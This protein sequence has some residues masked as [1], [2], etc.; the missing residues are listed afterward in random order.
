MNDLIGNN[1]E[2]TEE[3]LKAKKWMKI[4]GIILAI[5][6]VVCIALIVLIYYI[7]SSELKITVDAKSN[8]KL[9]SIL[10]FENDKVY[11]PIRAFAEYMNYESSNGD[12]QQDKYTEDATRCYVQNGSEAATFTLDS[13]KIYKTLLDDNNDYE[14]YEIDEPVKMIDNQLCTTINGARIAFNISMSYDVKQNRVTIFT[15]PYLVT[16][17]TNQF[18]NA[19]IAGDRASFSNQKAL[20]YNM[21]IVKNADNEYG[22]LDL[23]GKEILG[24]KY[25]DIK[26]IESTREFIVTTPENKMGIMSYDA[27]KGNAIT[28]ISPEYDEIKQIDKDTGLYVATNNKK[29]GVINSTGSIVVYLDYDQIGVDSTKFNNNNIKNQYLLYDNCI[30]VKRNNKWGL[31]DKTGKEILPVEYDELG[32]T[33]GSGTGTSNTQTASSNSVLL[34]PEYKAIVVK[35]GD[36]YGLVD[37]DGRELLQT[38]FKS[39]YSTTSAGKETYYM[40]YNDQL[41]NVVEYIRQYV[42]PESQVNSN[43]TNNVQNTQNN[44]IVNQ[45][46]SNST[47]NVN[48]EQTQNTMQTN[49]NVVN[50]N[51][52]VQNNTNIQQ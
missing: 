7:Q 13:N 1:Y 52:A 6:L 4:I 28:K 9:G 43:T 49:A 19:G 26:F 33:A 41:R 14:Y 29:Q 27:N 34:I 47:Q 42:K 17:Y 20:L 36:L 11:V 5:L 3:Q 51:T 50:Q 10:I 23:N 18:Q 30:P 22:V 2:P 48:Q 21:I 31:F 12:Y 16:Y 15:L 35:K 37:S 46:N 40:I 8:S 39:F 32:C 44:N 24:T 25:S 38:V 45:Q